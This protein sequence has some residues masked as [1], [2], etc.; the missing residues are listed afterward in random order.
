MLSDYTYQL[1][2]VSYI[3]SPFVYT[4]LKSIFPYCFY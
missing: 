3:S 4:H 1:E 2:I